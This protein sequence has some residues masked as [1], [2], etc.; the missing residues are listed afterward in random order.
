MDF[1]RRYLWLNENY[2]K[3]VCINKRTINKYLTKIFDSVREK[4]YL[5]NR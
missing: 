4:S 1:Y 2:L 3:R 5:C